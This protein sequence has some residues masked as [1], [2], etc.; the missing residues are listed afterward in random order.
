MTGFPA[1]VF[2]TNCYVLASEPGAECIV[3]DPGME[4]VPT[5]TQVLEEHR[6]K[7]VAIAL[8]HGHLDHTW[9]VT[10]LVDGYDIPAY[11]H[12]D[13]E[14]MVRD[15][16]G[17]HSSG[18]AQL[19]GGDIK[20]IP[21]IDDVRKLSDGEKISIVGVELTA[22]HTPGHTQG[23]VIFSFDHP[24]APVMLAGDT[25]FNQGIGRTDLAGGSYEAIM[26]SIENVCLTYPD[27]TV[28][29]PGH[30]AQTTIGA[31]RAMNP[32]ILEYLR[33]K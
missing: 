25:L 10:P 33:G 13:D 9:S 2:Q 20:K 11:L 5:L 7:P 21:T 14:D 27:E 1:G 22:R 12:G 6:L 26:H 30:G 19:V 24:Q 28:V 15:P 32:F 18:I 29:L 31:E 4:A 3:V 8:T 17:W 16:L 23:S